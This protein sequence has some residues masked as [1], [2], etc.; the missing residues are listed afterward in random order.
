MMVKDMRARE[1]ICL[2]MA[3]SKD[4]TQGDLTGPHWRPPLCGVPASPLDEPAHRLRRL[5]ALAASVYG[6][7]A[8]PARHKGTAVWHSGHIHP[9]FLKT[10]SWQMDQKREFAVFALRPGRLPAGPGDVTGCGRLHPQHSPAC[11]AVPRT[12]VYRR[13][14]PSSQ[15]EAVVEVSLSPRGIVAHLPATA[16]STGCVDRSGLRHRRA[17]PFAAPPRGGLYL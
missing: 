4:S 13:D 11:T 14:S 9:P 12:G 17:A 1:D 6:M 16:G 3:N 10:A 2:L 7:C 5:T 8:L 15:W